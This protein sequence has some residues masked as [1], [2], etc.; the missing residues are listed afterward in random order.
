MT[1]IDMQQRGIQ[2]GEVRDVT[3]LRAMLDAVSGALSRASSAI[4]GW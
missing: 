2:E 1:A 4:D 3:K